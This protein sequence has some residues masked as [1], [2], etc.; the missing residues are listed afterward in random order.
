MRY[1]FTILTILLLFA[2]CTQSNDESEAQKIVN[3]AIEVAGGENYEKAIIKFNFRNISY[4]SSRS[5]G[6]FKLERII[7]DSLGSETRDIL[8][9]SGL[10]R[11]KKNSAIKMEDSLIKP[12]SNSV[13]SVHYFIQIPFGLND[14]AVNKTLVG[15]DIINNHEYYEIKV[16]F[17]PGTSGSDHEDDYLYWINE[18][19]FTVDYLAYNFEVNEGG[20]RFRKAVNPRVINGL[21]FVDY[22]NYSYSDAN[23][24]LTRLDSL[25]TAGELRLVSKIV[26]EDIEVEINK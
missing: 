20:V 8:S 14:P 19:T 4:K 9:N 25:Y 26:N 21:R 16:T 22:E 11:F 18:E 2:S 23:V 24:D 6:E 5:N 1:T 17:D 3:K 12:I 7:I 13:N 10:K 15:R